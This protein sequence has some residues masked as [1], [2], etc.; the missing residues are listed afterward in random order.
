MSAVS[1]SI[2]YLNFYLEY[3]DRFKLVQLIL[4][5]VILTT[6]VFRVR[7][8][9][10]QPFVVL[11]NTAGYNQKDEIH[12]LIA[13]PEVI[14]VTETA[15]ALEIRHL[16][17][18]WRAHSN[19]TLPRHQFSAEDWDQLVSILLDRIRSQSPGAKILTARNPGG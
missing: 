18:G 3:G 12:G 13:F 2:Y 8:D 5:P 4:W 6:Q 11:T 16:P 7:A 9:S 1:L 10:R 19:P 15:S 17:E 14:E